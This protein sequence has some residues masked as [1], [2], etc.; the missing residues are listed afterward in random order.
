VVGWG[1]YAAVQQINGLHNLSGQRP[2]IGRRVAGHLFEKEE[3]H[4]MKFGMKSF[5]G[6]VGRFIKN[7]LDHMKHEYKEIR[8]S[9]RRVTR[10]LKHLF[11]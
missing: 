6:F 10:C 8:Y 9:T 5:V 7:E 3:R 1:Q 2:V 11:W 4:V